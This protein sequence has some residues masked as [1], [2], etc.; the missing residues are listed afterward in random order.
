MVLF[1]VLKSGLLSV[2]DTTATEQFFYYGS[3]AFLAGFNERF[4]NV[5]L[6]KAESTIA[7]TLGD[8]SSNRRARDGNEDDSA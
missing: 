2:K 3:L 6:G 1:F 5:I 4:T 8:S 7:P